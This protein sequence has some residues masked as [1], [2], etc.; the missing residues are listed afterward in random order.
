M[1]KYK[2]SRTEMS[3]EWVIR[4][5]KRDKIFMKEV[6]EDEQKNADGLRAQHKQSCPR[7]DKMVKNKTLESMRRSLFS[8]KC[9]ICYYKFINSLA[10][11]AHN[12]WYCKIDKCKL[13][14]LREL[15]PDFSINNLTGVVHYENCEQVDIKESWE[16]IKKKENLKKLDQMLNNIL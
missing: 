2:I 1:A 11:E 3:D 9:A 4:L 10:C 5:M 16:K 12:K 13:E 7:L 15:K 8:G 14:Q 6:A